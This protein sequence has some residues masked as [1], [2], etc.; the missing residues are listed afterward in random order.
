[1]PK[2]AVHAASSDRLG[3]FD[4]RLLQLQRR[5][6]GFQRPRRQAAK[7]RNQGRGQRFANLSFERRIR[8]L[9][10][11]ISPRQRMR[12]RL[13]LDQPRRRHLL[14]RRKLC[15]PRGRVLYRGERFIERLEVPLRGL[16]QH[17][18]CRGCVD[19]DRLR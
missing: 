16:C 12:L 7:E 4:Q 17:F 3:N 10:L 15:L 5:D 2:Y 19:A 11:F 8:S 18:H 1:M 9:Q 6:F 14:R 13:T